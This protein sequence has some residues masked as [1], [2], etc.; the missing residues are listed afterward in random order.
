MKKIPKISLGDI[1]NYISKHGKAAAGL[2][3]LLL[4]STAVSGCIED[5][6]K[7]YDK[8]GLSD[9][10]EKKYKTDP[11]D[12]DSD[13]DG[14]FD[15]DEVYKYKSD[16]LKPDTSGDGIND[17]L[18]IEL[19][20]DPREKSPVLAYAITKLPKEIVKNKLTPLRY[21]ELT[22]NIKNV[23]DALAQYPEDLEEVVNKDWFKNMIADGAVTDY[24]TWRVYDYDGDGVKNP[25]DGNRLNSD[26]DGDRGL[27]GRSIVLIGGK[28]PDLCKEL[29][30]K[31]IFHKENTD[32]SITFYG[33]EDIG[34]NPDEYDTDKDNM[35]DLF[36]EFKSKT[37]PL[38]EN[39]KYA[40]A[41]FMAEETSEKE[42]KIFE[43]ALERYGIPAENIICLSLPDATFENYQKSVKEL[44]S[45][46]TENDD[47]LIFIDKH[48]RKTSEF[49]SYIDELVKNDIKARSIFVEF[50][51][52]YSGI[53]I[54]E[55]NERK[56]DLPLVV[57]VSSPPDS[58]TGGLI[59]YFVFYSGIGYNHP[60]VEAFSFLDIEYYEEI[61]RQGIK[62]TDQIED[63][64]R[65]FNETDINDDS[66]VSFREVL[67]AYC[68]KKG[69][70]P[71][72]LSYDPNNLGESLFLGDIYNPLLLKK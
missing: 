41:V 52:C 60:D 46:I 26:R 37:N 7:D 30:E 35:G 59:D 42:P 40:L 12:S 33:E 38:V 44:T 16:P 4:L 24:E 71:L 49:Y 55:L 20:L 32:G 21:A 18:A 51:S 67:E 2:T 25:N 3:A 54:N 58:G 62:E 22:H 56:P 34:T 69:L 53:L 68:R 57:Y 43:K 64:Q 10:L 6:K 66:Y 36:E 13:D 28:D 63:V 50:D 9:Y 14:I 11:H 19:G 65:K 45:K 15:G 29:M 70:N 5:K 1:K 72:I 23:I 39:K 61:K 31:K 17:K 27:D 48:S 8:D 47:L